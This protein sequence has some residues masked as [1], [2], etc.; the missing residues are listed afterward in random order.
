MYPKRYK[1]LLD[2]LKNSFVINHGFEIIYIKQAHQVLSLYS[3]RYKN[4][5]YTEANLL[6]DAVPT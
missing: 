4:S 2:S 1:K 6:V 5:H 3:F